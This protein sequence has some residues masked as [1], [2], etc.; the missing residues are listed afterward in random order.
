MPPVLPLS[1]PSTCGDRQQ[2]ACESS[3]RKLYCHRRHHQQHYFVG[4]GAASFSPCFPAS[5]PAEVA[6][7]PAPV[8][9]EGEGEQETE[10]P[11]VVLPFIIIASSRVAGGDGD[12][13]DGTT[14]S[15]AA[16]PAT[17]AVVA[18]AASDAALLSST[19][20]P[21]VVRSPFS[22]AAALATAALAV[23]VTAALQQDHPLRRRRAGAEV[24]DGPCGGRLSDLPRGSQDLVR[25]D[26]SGRGVQKQQ[27]HCPETKYNH[28]NVVIIIIINRH[29]CHHCRHRQH[30]RHHRSSKRHQ[31]LDVRFLSHTSPCTGTRPCPWGASTPCTLPT[32]RRRP[33]PAAWPTEAA[34]CSWSSSAYRDAMFVRKTTDRQGRE[35]EQS[36]L[37]HQPASNRLANQRTSVSAGQYTILMF[38]RSGKVASVA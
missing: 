38:C 19:T 9:E 23:A 27:R 17:A 14:T 13:G 22:P 16:A 37:W 1:R 29:R 35:R 30:C 7:S 5:T 3:R 32:P 34:N 26:A 25:E 4:T 15:M 33:A 21:V 6:E 11:P 10:P 36:R 2:K 20:S 18:P 28:R 8:F 12:E 31:T 24:E